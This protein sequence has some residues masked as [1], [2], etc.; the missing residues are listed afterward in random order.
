MATETSTTGLSAADALALLMEVHEYG[1]ARGLR[2]DPLMVKVG[3]AVVRLK[4]PA[5]PPA[6]KAAPAKAE[7]VKA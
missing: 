7:T 4:P 6:A 5:P 3:E 2:D 1:V